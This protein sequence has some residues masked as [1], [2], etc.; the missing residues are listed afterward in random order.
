MKKDN[1]RNIE[2]GA[3]TAQEVA[4]VIGIT[5]R[6]V[7]YIIHKQHIPYHRVGTAIL[8]APVHLEKFRNRRKPGRPAAKKRQKKSTNKEGVTNV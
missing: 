8:V 5:R 2:R 7:L 3:M 4:E 1:I 6:S